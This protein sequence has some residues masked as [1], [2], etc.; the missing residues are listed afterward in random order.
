M[1]KPLHIIDRHTIARFEQPPRPQRDAPAADDDLE[2]DPPVQAE[3]P[4]V[5]AA[6]EPNYR[7]SDEPVDPVIGRHRN[8]QD[9]MQDLEA[10]VYRA[11]LDLRAQYHQIESLRTGLNERNQREA[12]HYARMEAHATTMELHNQRF[13]EFAA[14]QDMCFR[15]Q[16]THLNPG[17]DVFPNAPVW[18]PQ[19]PPMPQRDMSAEG[20]ADNVNDDRPRRQDDARGDDGEGGNDSDDGGSGDTVVM[21]YD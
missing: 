1:L 11:R 9:R 6:E 14:Y 2:P 20:V 19:Y 7:L 16:Q 8:V 13:L 18:L 10:E 5:P 3:V 15:M 21:T 4:P 12:A 17:Y